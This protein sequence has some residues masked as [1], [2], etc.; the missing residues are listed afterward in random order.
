[1]H[2]LVFLFLSFF[3][4]STAFASDKFRFETSKQCIDCDLSDFVAV[5]SN[6]NE[7]V[8]RNSDLSRCNLDGSTFD[9]SVFVNVILDHCSL[10]SAS[11]KNVD[12]SSSTLSHADVAGSDFTGAKISVAKFLSSYNWQYAK[13]FYHLSV[14]PSELFQ[15]ALDLYNSGG[16]E[17][18]LVLIDHLLLDD[19][20]LPSYLH[21]R[22]LVNLQ[23]GQ[24][25]VAIG[26]IFKSAD[27][28]LANG[29]TY[30]SD[31]L[32]RY[33]ED[34][35]ERISSEPDSLFKDASYLS[36]IIATAYWLLF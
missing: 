23:L 21:L 36:S 25:D 1:M 16:Y 31:A 26:D 24:E 4:G 13:N 14:S 29:D 19:E 6:F 3:A 9:N 7:S 34:I 5:N 8:L 2:I 10:Q 27:L 12:F 30:K 35:A 11:F 18:A 22:S 28:Y 32:R 20:I 17:Q 15:G 33:A